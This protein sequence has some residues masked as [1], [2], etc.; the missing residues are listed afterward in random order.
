[1]AKIPRPIRVS[2]NQI[3]P[4]WKKNSRLPVRQKSIELAAHGHIHHTIK[5][6]QNVFLNIFVAP[7]ALFVESSGGGHWAESVLVGCR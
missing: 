2:I 1:V 6:S 7:I 3:R 5:P 4:I